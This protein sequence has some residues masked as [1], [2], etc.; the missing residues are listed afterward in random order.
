MAHFYGTVQGQRGRASRLGSKQS[1]LDVTAASWQGAVSVTLREVDGVDHATI[2]LIQWNGAG[3][4][5][6]IY[7]G[8]VSGAGVF[9]AAP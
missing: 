6:I 3:T 8:P 2:S 1:G 9:E 7:D 4:R 5:R